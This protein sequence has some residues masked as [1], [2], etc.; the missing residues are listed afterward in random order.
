MAGPTSSMTTAYSLALDIVLR[1]LRRVCC[2][3]APKEGRCILHGDADGDDASGSDRATGT[4]H[5]LLH[6]H[7]FRML[8]AA[9]RAPVV[10]CTVG[11]AIE[12]TVRVQE[13]SDEHHAF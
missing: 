12:Q 2:S 9:T 13:L 11:F 5:N 1:T 8:R 3:R 6:R 7:P 10:L 4:A